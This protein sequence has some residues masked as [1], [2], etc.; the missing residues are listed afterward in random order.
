MK[1]LITVE[2]ISDLTGLKKLGFLGRALSMLLIRLS[3]INKFNVAYSK[4][5]SNKVDNF[6][7]SS[8]KVLKAKYEVEED[9]FSRIPDKGPVIIISNHPLGG[10][11]A[12]IQMRILKQVRP[13]FKLFGNFLVSQMPEIREHI[14]SVNPFKKGKSKRSANSFK[15]AIEHIKKGNAISFFPAGEVS[16]YKFKK[17]R[18]F[19]SEWDKSVIKFIIKMNVPIVPIY[20][21]ARNSKLFYI[22]SS[23]CSILGS[24]ML[25]RELFRKNMKPVGVKIGKKIVIKDYKELG[26]DLNLVRDFLVKKTYILENS[27][28]SNNISEESKKTNIKPIINEQPKELILD[29]IKILREN[30]NCIFESNNYSVFFASS[31]LI[32]NILKEIGRL[33]EI[34]FRDMGEG[35]DKEIDLDDYDYYYKHLFLWDSSANRIVGAYRLGI[36]DNIYK[37]RGIKGFYINELF[38]FDKGFETIVSKSIEMGRAFIITDYQRKTLP[39][40]LIWKGVAYVA[41]SFPDH[42]YLLGCVSI[43]NKFS[44]F[45]KSMMI[46]FM[47]S[48]YYDPYL[49]QYV[50]PKN[51]Y[52]IKLNEDY[53]HF[54]FKTTKSDINKFNN[55]IDEIENEN[56]R[57]PILIKKYIKQNAKVISFSV[58]PDFNNTIDGLMYVK[59]SDLPSSTVKP[60]I[61]EIKNNADNANIFKKKI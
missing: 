36:G 25:P 42:K 37:E 24:L 3:G 21:H 26:D 15:Q 20:F 19:D 59:I 30:N 11:D 39:L 56:L 22:L 34:T 61:D 10:V 40:Y 35:T 2:K 60:I 33:R 48:N 41:L 49:A 58:D 5:I 57:L 50:H 17:G 31:D 32:P 23:I 38:N 45:S 54:V 12:L 9:S 18:I 51:A 43:S 46:E 6:F 27:F 4:T 28:V 47:K 52:K 29:E 16:R 53:K 8:L 7:V 1:K 13:D 55:I 14:I 44:S